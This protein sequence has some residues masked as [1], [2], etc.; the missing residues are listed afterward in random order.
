MGRQQ[1]HISDPQNPP[2][3]TYDELLGPF[4]D[5]MLVL[6]SHNKT[7]PCQVKLVKEMSVRFSESHLL[8]TVCPWFSVGI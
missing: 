2:W 4:P 3:S 7:L 8:A 5:V 1:L 6:S